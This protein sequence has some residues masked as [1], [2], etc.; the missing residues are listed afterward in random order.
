[1]T[2]A[3]I[4]YRIG[5]AWRRLACAALLAVGL[6]GGLA[7]QN[8]PEERQAAIAEWLE[9]SELDGLRALAGLARA[10]DT[11]AQLFLGLVDKSTELQGPAVAALTRAER[12]ELLRAPGGM[13]GRSWVDVAAAGGDPLAQAWRDLWS[14]QA[15]LDTAETFA[16]AQEPRALAEALL[17]LV[18]RQDTGFAP[19]VLARDWYPPALLMLSETRVLR[20][21]DAARLH[22]GDPQQRF[23]PNG[24][25]QAQA[26]QDWLAHSTPALPLRA[27]CAAQ[28]AATQASCV[29]ALYT[30]LGDYEA[31]VTLGS[32]VAALVPDAV[33][34]ESPRGQAALARRIMLMRSTRMREAER[35]KLTEVDA[36]AADWLAVQYDAYTMRKLPAPE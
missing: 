30:A 17:T 14:M 2:Q 9:G 16:R 3:G 20:E 6:T 4:R 24:A 23:G 13:S 36:C 12:L 32:P 31:L 25:P 7:A 34:A 21:H 11:D 18:K 15:S 26:L 5:T 35:Q 33:F 27:V 8:T 19:D 1:M 28:C 29:M 10:G 22:P